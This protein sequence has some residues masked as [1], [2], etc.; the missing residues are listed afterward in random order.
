MFIDFLKDM[1]MCTVN[2]RITPEL[3]NFTCLNT[4]GNSVIDYIITEQ[5]SINRC[6][7]CVVHTVNDLVSSCEELKSMISSQ[8]KAPDHSVV[9]VEIKISNKCSEM[10]GNQTKKSKS[11][12]KYS[13]HNQNVNF[14]NNTVLNAAVVEIISQ[15][16]NNILVNAEFDNLYDRLVKMILNEMD[17]YLEF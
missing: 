7:K 8:C 1:K 4:M 3:D 17:N 14:L 13:F 15:L 11:T 2:G 5:R 9:S 12:R 10:S 6:V 16:E